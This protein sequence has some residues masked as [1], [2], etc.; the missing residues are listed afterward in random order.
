L[1]VICIN[2][3][4]TGNVIRDSCLEAHVFAETYRCHGEN[5]DAVKRYTSQMRFA[6]DLRSKKI[7]IAAFLTTNGVN[8]VVTNQ[9]RVGRVFE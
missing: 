1:I 9:R 7:S 6:L 4:F 2:N 3:K 5:P 8:I